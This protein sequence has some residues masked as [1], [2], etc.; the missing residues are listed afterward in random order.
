MIDYNAPEFLAERNKDRCSNC[1]VCVRQCANEVHTID[2]DTKDVV[3][4][5]MKC[6]NCHRCVVMCP[7]RALIIRKYP[8]EYRENANW[9]DRAIKEVIKQADTGAVLLSG[10][11]NPQPY[12]IYWDK[13]LLNASQVTNPSI[14]PLREPMETRTFLGRKPSILKFDEEGRNADHHLRHVLRID[15]AQCAEGD[16]N[17]GER[18]QYVFQY[19]RRRTS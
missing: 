12:P 1:G 14:D 11:G 2:P 3:S 16:C 7:T 8:L 15:L 6:V 19:R 18:M 10:M 9:N 13:M 5:E 17:G 4:D